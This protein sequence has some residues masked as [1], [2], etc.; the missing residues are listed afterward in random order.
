MKEL[1]KYF[2]KLSVNT[3]PNERH[4]IPLFALDVIFQAMRKKRVYQSMG[5]TL[6]RSGDPGEEGQM[7]TDSVT[8]ATSRRGEYIRWKWVQEWADWVDHSSGSLLAGTA[9]EAP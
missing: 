3:S 1:F 8:Q 5:F 6:P 2:T 9:V 4:R 7:L